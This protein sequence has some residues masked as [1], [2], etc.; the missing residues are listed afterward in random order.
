[1]KT[2]LVSGVS[3]FL[4]KAVIEKLLASGFNVVGISRSNCSMQHKNFRLVKADISDYNQLQSAVDGIDRIDCFIHLAAKIYYGDD[5]DSCEEMITANIIGSYNATRLVNEKKIKL[6]IYAST[7]SVYSGHGVVTELTAPNPDSLY[8]LTK[9]VPE[10]F[11]KRLG[12]W[13]NSYILRFSGIYG[14]GR[15]DGLIYRIVNTYAKNKAFDLGSDGM[16]KWNPL[17]IDDAVNSIIFFITPGIKKSLG[18]YNVGLDAQ[19]SIIGINQLLNKITGKDLVKF[20]DKKSTLDFFMS[21]DKIKKIGF[22]FEDIEVSLSKFYRGL[23]GG[24]L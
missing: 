15:D 24:K 13:C 18:I 22:E 1:M 19:V 14:P 4:G 23:G 8:G 2:I 3:G 6:F 17:Y 10:F 21:V 5:P 12:K 9:L 11:V 16:D 20:S 7:M